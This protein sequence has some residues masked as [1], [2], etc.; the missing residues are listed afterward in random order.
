MKL[1]LCLYIYISGYCCIRIGSDFCFHCS[2]Y[3]NTQL[4]IWVCA[5]QY[6]FEVS[7]RLLNYCETKSGAPSSKVWWDLYDG[8]L[9]LN[10]WLLVAWVWHDSIRFDFASFLK[11]LPIGLAL[12]GNRDWWVE[13]RLF[14]SR[15]SRPRHVRAKALIPQ[16]WSA[17]DVF[18]FLMH[19][20]FVWWDPC[21]T[22]SQKH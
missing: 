20:G 19:K 5:Q 16:H 22:W 15:C 18:A 2:F 12:L 7:Q 17:Q 1:V 13:L 9:Y 14:W 6:S 21:H 8:L 10:L 3:C 4:I 11:S